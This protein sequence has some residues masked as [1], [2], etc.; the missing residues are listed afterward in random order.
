[1]TVKDAIERE[2]MYFSTH[3]IYSTMPA[4]TLGTEVLT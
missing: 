1:M 2:K 3:P 4:T